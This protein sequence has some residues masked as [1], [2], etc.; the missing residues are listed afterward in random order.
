MILLEITDRE[1]VR[2][3]KTNGGIFYPFIILLKIELKGFTPYSMNTC[4]SHQGQCEN[5]ENEIRISSKIGQAIPI[6]SKNQTTQ[7]V[8]PR[9][10][11]GTE[12]IFLLPLKMT[13]FRS[14]FFIQYHL[15]VLFKIY[16]Q[17]RKI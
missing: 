7:R 3:G 6:Q 5:G 13:N 16:L 11:S 4:F 9:R 1:R 14:I 12:T 8:S 15:H 17:I 10:T 2:R